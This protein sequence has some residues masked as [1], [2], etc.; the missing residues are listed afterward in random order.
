M[1]HKD[2]RRFKNENKHIYGGRKKMWKQMT[3]KPKWKTSQQHRLSFLFCFSSLF[4]YYHTPTPLTLLL[5]IC[6]KKTTNCSEDTKCFFLFFECSRTDYIFFSPA[7]AKTIWKWNRIGCKKRETQTDK[8][9][10]IMR[11]KQLW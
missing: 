5:E 6:K 4:L 1:P 3:A 2:K 9:T 10:Q 7:I 11:Y 8:R